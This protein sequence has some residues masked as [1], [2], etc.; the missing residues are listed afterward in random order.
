MRLRLCFLAS[1]PFLAASMSVA[2]AQVPNTVFPHPLFPLHGVPTDMKLRDLD[3]DGVLDL[4]SL[5]WGTF[6]TEVG[7]SKGTVSGGFV[8]STS[9]PAANSNVGMALADFNGD[10]W[11]DVA[12]ALDDNGYHYGSY[13][14]LR[15]KSDGTFMVPWSHAVTFNPNSIAAG[16]IDR[17]GDPD[18]LLGDGKASSAQAWWLRGGVGA[19]FSSPQPLDMGPQPHDVALADVDGDGWLDALALVAGSLVVRRGTGSASDP[20]AVVQSS[21]LPGNGRSLLLADLDEDGVLDAAV[22]DLQYGPSHVMVLRGHGDGSFAPA[23]SYDV[24]SHAFRLV[25]GDFDGD[26]HVDLVSENLGSFEGPSLS[27]L[28]STGTGSFAA[29]R[30]FVGFGPLQSIAAADLN[31]DGR[32]DLVIGQRSGVASADRGDVVTLFAESDGSFAPYPTTDV[33]AILYAGMVGD[34]DGDGAGDLA[35]LVQR[36]NQA[37]EV[38]VLRGDLRGH[39]QVTQQFEAEGSELLDLRSAD[40]DGDTHAD[41]AVLRRGLG[42]PR[43]S[44]AIFHGRPDGTF[45]SAPSLVGGAPT[46]GMAI[47][48]LDGDGHADVVNALRQ[49]YLIVNRGSGSAGGFH[50]PA[51]LGL[52]SCAASVVLADFNGDGRDDVIT[53]ST[54]D[55][56]FALLL[57]QAGGGFDDPVDLSSLGGLQWV[58]PGDFDGDGNLD[59]LFRSIVG[60]TDRIEYAPGRGDGTFDAARVICE[61]AVA[62]RFI[63]IGDFDLDGITDIVL[64]SNSLVTFR[65]LGGGSFAAPERT[66]APWYFCGAGVFDVD[67]DGDLDIV[68]AGWP[69]T[70][71]VTLL[72]RTIP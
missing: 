58:Q 59:L 35:A 56:R 62:A 21:A 13:T 64:S 30:R 57:S 60:Y 65:G 6:G 26:G 15:G 53:T 48:D 68:G 29:E 67:S 32:T 45:E 19:T 9:S 16:D 11:L 66:M 54:L 2:L 55:Y 49:N 71:F 33:G 22:A 10:G 24:A 72:N 40:F 47:G 42:A 39:F 12:A 61:T 27:L 20:F 5:S 52:P 36:P 23:T 63:G 4:L 43:R 34:F 28:R 69:C 7:V 3:S 41:L 18:L 1:S 17:D 8:P 38:D 46:F 31:G 37:R 44:I 51:R 70:T 25:L 14:V 50:A